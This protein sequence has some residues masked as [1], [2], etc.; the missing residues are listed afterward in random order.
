MFIISEDTHEAWI[1]YFS[2]GSRGS[3]ILKFFVAA[4]EDTP[5]TAPLAF[6]NQPEPLWHFR[7][8]L[9]PSSLQQSVDSR[10]DRGTSCPPQHRRRTQYSQCQSDDW[11]FAAFKQGLQ[12]VQQDRV[13]TYFSTEQNKAWIENECQVQDHI[14]QNGCAVLQ[15]PFCVCVARNRQVPNVR[16]MT[17]S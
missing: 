14:C 5:T 6:S 1:R 7:L 17:Y 2:A 11:E 12:F 13:V 8:D 10:F 15:N 3:S 9:L 16:R 4:G